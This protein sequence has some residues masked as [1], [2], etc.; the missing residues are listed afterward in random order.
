MLY[1]DDQTQLFGYAAA[2]LLAAIAAAT[3]WK[4]GAI[5][6]WLTLPPLVVAPVVY[7]IAHGWTG[8]VVSLGGLVICGLVPFLLWRQGAIGGGDVKFVAAVGASAGIL[9]GLEVELVAFVV[10][11][12]YAMGR[13]AWDGE[14]IKTLGNSFFLALNPLLPKKWRRKISPSLLHTVRMGGSF[15]AAGVVTFLARHPEFYT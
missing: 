12:L 2:I 9:V 3:D 4:T 15:L 14:L 1:L 8:V 6:N 11:G 10:A 7:G 5:P 13:L